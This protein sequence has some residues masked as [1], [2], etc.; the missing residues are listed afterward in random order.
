[1]ICDKSN[2]SLSRGKNEAVLSTPFKLQYLAKNSDKLG[3]YDK[4]AYLGLSFTN[5][6]DAGTSISDNL[7]CIQKSSSLLEVDLLA[8]KA[9]ALLLVFKQMTTHDL[10]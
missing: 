10:S 3:A 7:N 4:N 1:M 5:K 9:D 8:L 6:W 2:I